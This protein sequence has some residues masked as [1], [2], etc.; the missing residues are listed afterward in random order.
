MRTVIFDLDGTL[1]DTSGDLLAA[2]NACFQALGHGP[3]LDPQADRKTAFAGGRAMLTLG[4]QRLAQVLDGVDVPAL[5]EQEFPRFITFYTDAIDRHSRMYPGAVA[6]IEAL[7]A[8]GYRVGI[9]TNK[10][11]EQSEKL[12]RA[13]GVREL[14]ASLVCADTLATRKPDAAPFLEAV[15]RT[16]GDPGRAMLVG[17]TITDRDCARAAG[18]PCLLVTFGPDPEAVVAMQPE[19]LLAGFGDLARE[20]RALIG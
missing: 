14:F 12:L 11:E 3:V 5:V 15:A 2:A 10:P 4:F 1:A 9:C 20:V 18:V 17:D 13:L 16:G 6:A 8:D 7:I 19:G